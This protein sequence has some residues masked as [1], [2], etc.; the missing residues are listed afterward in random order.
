MMTKSSYNTKNR[1]Q[2]KKNPKGQHTLLYIVIMEKYT[3]IDF[4]S[5]EWGTINNSDVPRISSNSND[6]K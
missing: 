6:N 3:L 5:N 4:T 2:N 1:N